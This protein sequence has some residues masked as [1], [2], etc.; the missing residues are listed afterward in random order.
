MAFNNFLIFDFITN[1][2]F[3]TVQPDWSHGAHVLCSKLFDNM[4]NRV[5][6][7]VVTLDCS[8]ADIIFCVLINGHCIDFWNINWHYNFL[9]CN[10]T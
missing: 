9:Y 2:R 8:I 7:E 3:L 6:L 10:L 1:N 5:F 4:L